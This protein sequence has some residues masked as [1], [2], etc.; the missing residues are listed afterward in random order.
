M[1]EKNP[2]EDPNHKPKVSD[3]TIIVPTP[4]RKR[5]GE[6]QT[7]GLPAPSLKDVDYSSTL[8]KATKNPLVR[9][10]EALFALARALRT[11]PDHEDISGLRKRILN[12]LRKFEMEVLGLGVNKETAQLSS[13]SL[14]ALLDDMVLA[15][16]WGIQS[17]WSRDRLLDTLYDDAQGGEK[18]FKILETVLEQPEQS[19]DFLE[20]IFVCLSLGFQGKYAFIERGSQKLEEIKQNLY[21]TIQNQRGETERDLSV[22]WQGA[23]D[24]SPAIMRFIP[25]WVIPVAAC[26]VATLIYFV[27]NYYINQFSSEVY[28]KLNNLGNEAIQLNQSPDI[29]NGPPPSSSLETLPPKSEPSLADRISFKLEKEVERGLVDINQVGYLTN[30]IVFNDGMFPAENARVNETFYPL[31]NKVGAVLDTIPGSIFVIGH[32]GN[33]P[34]R[35]LKYPSNWDLSLA[36]AEAVV[37]I[38]SSSIR[39]PERLKAEGRADTEPLFGDSTPEDRQNNSRIEI[40]IPR[41]L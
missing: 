38:L 18:F 34:I 15:T 6:D 14:C 7:W 16:P 20:F 13:Y 9:S 23:K 32:T 24:K 10:G 26:V 5:R 2:F 30:I 33:Q 19:I 3:R 12:M 22:H 8:D 25:L 36:R 1:T 40:R 4:G 27:F 29:L 35:T 17:Y 28:T 11:M 37:K 41:I 31:L 39:E 21:R